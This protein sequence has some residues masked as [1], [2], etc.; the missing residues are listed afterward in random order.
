MNPDTE[1][2]MV[3]R[4][5]TVDDAGAAAALHAGQISEG[6]LSILGPKFLRQALP[7]SRPHPWVLPAGC[8][9][10]NGRPVGFLA[11]SVRRGRPLSVVRPARRCGRWRSLAPA[12]FFAPGVG[13]S[14]PFVMAPAAL[15]TAPNCWPLPS[16]RRRADAV[17]ERC[18]CIGF[19]PRS[20]AGGRTPP[21]S[22]WRRDNETAIALYRRAGFEAAGAVR[23]A[24]RHR[25]PSD[26]VARPAG[27]RAA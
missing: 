20:S 15:P 18:W 12:G 16:I 3:L 6:F 17:P 13:C 7:A 27:D 24:P 23:T 22:W 14:R 2:G 19:L 21:T 10:W 8:P 11:G 5:G 25:V 26:A 9:G 4:T 1:N